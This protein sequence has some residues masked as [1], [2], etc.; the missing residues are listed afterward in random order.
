MK[1]TL[2]SLDLGGMCRLGMLQRLLVHGCS[3]LG[4]LRMARPQRRDH[5]FV[6]GSD[7]GDMR[8]VA[9]LEVREFALE[10]GVLRLLVGQRPLQLGDGPEVVVDGSLR[11]GTNAAGCC[12][13]CCANRSPRCKHG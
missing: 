12:C 10:F 1:L 2:R 13:R 7:G 8:L 11:C 4:L 3:V 9:V 5:G 6:F